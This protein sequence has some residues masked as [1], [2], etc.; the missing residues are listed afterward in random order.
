MKLPSQSALLT[1]CSVLALAACSP[2]F[3]WR[4]VQA[5]EGD[6]SGV[7]SVFPCRPDRHSRSI[8]LSGSTVT[9]HMLSCSAGGSTFALSHVAGAEPA[10]LGVALQALRDA[11]ARNVGAPPTVRGPAAVSGMTPQPLAQRLEFEGRRADG[12][13]LRM[14]A[15]FFA[16]GTD[17]HQATAVGTTLDADAVDTFFAGLRVPR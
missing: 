2:I 13:P 11:A 9:M 4:E 10:K 14:Q 3:D 15:L 12:G 8:E 7:L 6:A 1:A 5:A 16:A 17:I